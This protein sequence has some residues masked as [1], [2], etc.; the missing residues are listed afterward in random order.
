[1]KQ[2]QV[3]IAFVCLANFCLAQTQETRRLDSI[4]IV[5]YQQNQ[6]NGSV[7]IAD[8]GQVLYEKGFG[9]RNEQ[10][11]KEINS[12]TVFELASCS[13]QFTAAGIVLLKR[14]GKLDY[15]DKLT[16]YI[17]EL[18]QWDK[19]TLYDLLR[20][21]S[22]I[23]DFIGDMRDNW[24]QNTIATNNDVIQFYAKRNDTLQFEPKSNHRYSNTNY[25]LLAMIIERV[26]G[27]KYADF[28][29]QYIFKPLKMR[30]TFVYNR[31]QSPKKIE[32]YAIG[33]VWAKNSFEKVTADDPKYGA[34]TVYYLDGVVGSAKVNATVS[35]VYKW[36]SALK[37]GTFFTPEEFAAITEITQTT[38]GKSVAYG[39]GL[40]VRKGENKFTYGHTGS[41]DGYSTFIYH[42][43]IKDRTIIILENFNLGVVP[44]N[45]ITQI[46]DKS[47]ITPDF[48]KK[49]AIAETTLQRYTGKYTDQEEK[50]EQHL[51]TYKE[52][53][54]IYNSTTAA[55]DMRFFPISEKEFKGIRQGGADA[56]LRFVTNEAGKMTMEMLQNDQK[57]GFGIREE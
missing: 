15:T 55:W 6:F 20:H 35:D 33:Y 18:K 1:M 45:T 44:F 4:F 50:S 39:F 40:D 19:V 57:I 22:G 49:A 54:L 9:V 28:L 51:I 48:K 26:S 53:H 21:T 34:K 17:P 14:Q 27:K 43:Q 24:N 56:T 13:K 3:V 46:L 2:L 12:N 37:S 36:I 41:W 38:K 10:S 29:T 52:G 25:A 7:L 11:R 23:P 30:D 32:N 47:P 16:K 8:K 5:L 31:R 42:N